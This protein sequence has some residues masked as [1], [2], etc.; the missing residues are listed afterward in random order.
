MR[1][2][3]RAKKLSL[4]PPKQQSLQDQLLATSLEAQ[5]NDISRQ[6]GDRKQIIERQDELLSHDR[7]IRELMGARDLYIAEVYD[8]AGSGATQKP[9]GRVF[10]TKGKSLIFYTFNRGGDCAK[11]SSTGVALDNG[12][13]WKRRWKGTVPSRLCA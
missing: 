4:N 9:Y 11:T 6:L 10:Y 8:I 12:C 2:N 3:T 5:I 1:S 7:D 13:V